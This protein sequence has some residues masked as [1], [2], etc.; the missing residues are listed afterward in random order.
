MERALRVIG[1]RSEQLR[2]LPC[3]GEFRLSLEALEREVAQDA[4]AGLR[5]FCVVAN[6]GTTNTGA[7]DPLP[8]LARFCRE[9]GLWL[10]ADGAYGAAAMLCE[11]GRAALAGIQEA[12][13]LSLDPH[14]WL[15]Q[16]IETG[17]VLVRDMPCCATPSASCP[18]TSATRTG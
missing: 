2:K 12:D 6:A 4:A 1:F 8:A 10:H 13:S 18:P 9:R 3:D 15:F 17:C 16:P 7:V 11:E 14:K 5:P